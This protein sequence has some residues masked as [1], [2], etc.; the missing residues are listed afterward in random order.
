MGVISMVI[1]TLGMCFEL[2]GM[3]G[4]GMTW[5]WGGI[6]LV[7]VGGILWGVTGSDTSRS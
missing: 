3:L 1:F 7:M 6:V 5:T 4:A 2:A